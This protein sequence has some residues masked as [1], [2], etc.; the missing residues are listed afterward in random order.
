MKEN[1]LNIVFIDTQSKWVIAIKTQS[2]TIDNSSE[3]VIR[4]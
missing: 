3:I 4:I 1:N 2:N